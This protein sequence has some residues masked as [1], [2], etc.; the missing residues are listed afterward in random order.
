LEGEGI[1][2]RLIFE[3]GTLLKDHLCDLVDFFVS[4][5][6]NGDLEIFSVTFGV[7]EASVGVETNVLSI[8]MFGIQF[9]A[10]LSVGTE[11]SDSK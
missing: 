1:D 11:I 7:R 9:G 10:L 2:K 6:V 8:R 3:I 5:E 4:S